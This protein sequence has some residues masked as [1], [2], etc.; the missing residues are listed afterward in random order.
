MFWVC[1]SLNSSLSSFPL[2][3]LRHLWTV[4]F[5]SHLH[6]F[7]SFSKV[8]FSRRIL[9]Y[10]HHL[11]HQFLYSKSSTKGNIF[12][13]WKH[14]SAL[15][16]CHSI[17]QHSRVR[18]FLSVCVCEREWEWENNTSVTTEKS[19]FFSSRDKKSQ[20]FQL[21]PSPIFVTLSWFQILYSSDCF[22]LPL[23]LVSSILFQLPSRLFTFS[24]LFVIFSSCRHLFLLFLC[25]SIAPAEFDLP[26]LFFLYNICGFLLLCVFLFFLLFLYVFLGFVPM[27]LF[28]PTNST[29]FRAV[30]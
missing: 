15:K 22:P 26:V 4:S 17:Q 12:I 13:Q 29:L 24:K 28:S 3:C 25:S 30:V 14:F 10:F 20:T 7:T 19:A 18:V 11:P 9:S 6:L 21:S 16:H 23:S 27:E 2:Q 5:L 8:H 1:L